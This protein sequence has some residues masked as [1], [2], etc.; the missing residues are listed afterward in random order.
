MFFNL[1]C[2]LKG[3]G[4]PIQD[5]NGFCQEGRFV[6]K[7]IQYLYNLQQSIERTY[8]ELFV[9]LTCHNERILMAV[10][11][12]INERWLISWVTVIVTENTLC[13]KR[14]TPCLIL[15]INIKRCACIL[16]IVGYF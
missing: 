4:G 5:Y 9:W 10:L 15:N 12:R 8:S 14:T 6:I 1:Y 2:K 3:D 11:S 16:Q 13:G 7:L